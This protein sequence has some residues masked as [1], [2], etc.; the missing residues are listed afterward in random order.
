MVDSFAGFSGMADSYSNDAGSIDALVT[1]FSA[2]SEQL[3]ASINGVMDAIGE[4][5]K[6]ATEGATGTN[7]IAEKTG[8]VVEKAAEIKEKAEAAHAAADKLQ[9][10]VEHFIV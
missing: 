5:S 10:N 1:D 8:V 9:Q 7:D 6:A 4:V 3:L 2:S